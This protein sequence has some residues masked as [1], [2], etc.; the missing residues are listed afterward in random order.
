MF[1]TMMQVLTPQFWRWCKFKR[2]ELGLGIRSD[3]NQIGGGWDRPIL[4][5]RATC[6]AISPLEIRVLTHALTY[7]HAFAQIICTEKIKGRQY[8]RVKWKGAYMLSDELDLHVWVASDKL[9]DL[10]Y[11]HRPLNQAQHLGAAR[12]L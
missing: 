5:K 11:T 2:D 12:K 8:W 9:A 1:V 3:G 10:T 6:S 4:C 7:A